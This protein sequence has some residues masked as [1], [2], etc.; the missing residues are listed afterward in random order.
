MHMTTVE[1]TGNENSLMNC[2]HKQEGYC[3]YTSFV[4]VQ[5]DG[6]ECDGDECDEDDS[7][8]ECTDNDVR[9]VG[10]LN[11]KE[12]QV[13]VCLSGVWGTVCGSGWDENSA[14]VV[15]R[16]LGHEWSG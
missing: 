13:E 9:I 16:Q 1:C 12:G 6:D 2:S 3:D 11:A 7:D 5:C 15:C 14:K 10:G 4:R 8:D